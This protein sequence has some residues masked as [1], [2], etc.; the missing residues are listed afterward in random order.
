MSME[1]EKQKAQQTI[2]KVT[3]RM[4]KSL[5][6]VEPVRLLLTVLREALKEKLQSDRY[7]HSG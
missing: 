2:D 6:E 3:E 5:Q 1:S 7:D 4:N